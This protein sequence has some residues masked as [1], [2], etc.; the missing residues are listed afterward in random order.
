MCTWKRRER[1]FPS[2]VTWRNLFV[3]MACLEIPHGEPVKGEWI[4][5][6]HNLSFEVVHCQNALRFRCILY[7]ISLLNSVA[8]QNHF[9]L[10]NPLHHWEMCQDIFKSPSISNYS[11]K[12]FW[13][14]S[15]NHLRTIKNF[16]RFWRESWHCRRFLWF[17][18]SLCQ[19]FPT[20]L[21]FIISF[22]EHLQFY[23]NRN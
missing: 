1:S 6:E 2:L 9:S 12:C 14:I 16:W 8:L 3:D 22:N 18:R 5:W 21:L 7:R 20:D 4:N 15:L 23:L 19:V 10:W 17:L 13:S 11:L